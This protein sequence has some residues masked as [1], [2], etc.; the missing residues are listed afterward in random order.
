MKKAI[1]VAAVLAVMLMAT[2]CQV[3]HLSLWGEALKLPWG[4]RPVTGLELGLLADAPEVTGMQ[5]GV[6]LAVGQ[7]D[8]TGLQFAGF[9]AGGRG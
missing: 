8:G 9:G 3:F 6:V 1:Y 2:G 7:G 5:L 4:E